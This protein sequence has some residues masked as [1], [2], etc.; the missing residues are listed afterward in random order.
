MP[1]QPPDRVYRTWIIDSRRWTEYRPRPGDIVIAT[2]PKCGT[3]WM[4]RIVGMLVFQSA[5]AM[6]VMQMAP[7]IDKRFPDPIET[8]MARIEAQQ[9]RR[10]LKAHV[11]PDGLPLHGEVRYIHVGRDGRDAC[12]SFHHHAVGF[13]P[14]VLEMLDRQGLA[15]ET[16]AAS[17][18]RMPAD[19]ADH[20][21][22]WLTESAV[23]GDADGMPTMSFFH[24][25][26][27]WWD[28]RHRE[29]VLLVH[30]N[31]LARDLPGEMR[32]VAA[33]LGIEVPAGLWP[34]IVDAARFE[35]M[36]RDGAVLMGQTA[37]MFRDASAHFFHRGMNERWRGVFRKPDLALYDEKLAALPPECARW[38]MEGSAAAVP[39]GEYGSGHVRATQHIG[40]GT[41]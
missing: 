31:D 29:N 17:Y 10:F 19:P 15:D 25:E 2:Y 5:E 13:A 28:L 18:P 41:A 9:H 36:R 16:I 7:W 11:P 38:I 23:P 3:T 22:R 14:Q 21:H 6:P 39:E 27:S 8:V 40:G 20:F 34:A 1:V 4:Q 37:G 24:T 12:M 33:F 30:Y 26:Q 35:A 32:R